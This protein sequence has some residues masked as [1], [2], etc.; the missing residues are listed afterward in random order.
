MLLKKHGGLFNQKELQ[1]RLG[2]GKSTLSNWIVND[3]HPSGNN[4]PELYAKL[5]EIEAE[6]RFKQGTDKPEKHTGYKQTPRPSNRDFMAPILLTDPTHRREVPPVSIDEN[7]FVSVQQASNVELMQR[8]WKT[9]KERDEWKEE[10]KRL[11]EKIDAIE[12][13]IIK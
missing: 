1:L 4:V 2:V 5:A 13:I 7:D 11:K 3:V 9:E 10:A 8:I 6:I 12:S